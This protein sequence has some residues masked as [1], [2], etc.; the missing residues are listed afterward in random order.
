MVSSDFSRSHCYCGFDHGQLSV[1]LCRVIQTTQIPAPKDL[2]TTILRTLYS[3][4]ESEREIQT[5]Q[6]FEQL[7]KLSMYYH[8][9]TSLLLEIHQHRR[10]K[11]TSD[12]TVYN[13]A[14]DIFTQ[15]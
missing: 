11:L 14:S 7:I 5:G 15:K 13:S 12:G 8:F 10:V 4:I 1:I 6:K 3:K 2:R 9:L